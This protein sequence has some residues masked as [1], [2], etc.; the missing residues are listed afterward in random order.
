METS[1][2]EFNKNPFAKPED[3]HSIGVAHPK[4]LLRLQQIG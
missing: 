4:Q 1:M 2:I 3:T